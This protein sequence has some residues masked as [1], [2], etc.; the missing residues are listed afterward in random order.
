L[1]KVRILSVGK[2]SFISA[3]LMMLT[4][5]VTQA[6]Q[7]PTAPLG[8]SAPTKKQVSKRSYVPTLQSILCD[9][10]DTCT[11]ILNDVSIGLGGKVSGYTLTHIQD[12]FVTVSRGGK[13][14]RL[15]LFADNIKIIER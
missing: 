5:G 6:S 13:Q 2:F 14:W 1:A 15:E 10:S 11:A 8:W 4:T 7:D 9:E 3:I 12:D